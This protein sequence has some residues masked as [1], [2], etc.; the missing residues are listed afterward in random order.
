MYK[1]GVVE[2]RDL[3]D[4]GNMGIAARRMMGYK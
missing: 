2:V 3:I 1:S 4:P